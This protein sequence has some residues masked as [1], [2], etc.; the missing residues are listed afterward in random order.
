MEDPSDEM[1]ESLCAMY[2]PMV[3]VV[4]V[5]MGKAP[6]SLEAW[7]ACLLLCPHM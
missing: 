6:I 5:V 2:M 7:A 3:V 4:T 1:L